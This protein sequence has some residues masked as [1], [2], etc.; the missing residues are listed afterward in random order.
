MT[1]NLDRLAADMPYRVVFHGN[2]F[3]SIADSEIRDQI[4]TRIRNLEAQKLGT[5]ME[6]IEA[7]AVLASDL[8][9]VTEV[10]MPAPHG[11]IHGGHNPTDVEAYRDNL[12]K[13]VDEYD[14]RIT[15]LLTQLRVVEED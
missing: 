9:P 7:E 11:H 3:Y 14:I 1:T 8:L 2:T 13:A 12:R 10:A 5:V 6:L 15:A 4:R